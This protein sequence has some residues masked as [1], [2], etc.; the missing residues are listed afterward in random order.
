M[1]RAALLVSTKNKTTAEINRVTIKLFEPVKPAFWKTMT[2]DN[3]R[4][5]CGHEK[6]S[7]RLKL[8]SFF[9]NPYHS[10]ERG[11][12]EHT[13]GLIREFYPKSKNFK[14]VK[15]EDFQKAVDSSNRRPRKSLDYRTPLRSILC[16][17]RPCCISSLNWRKM[18]LSPFLLINSVL[19]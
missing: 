9:A 1:L 8:E 4:E 10:W 3:G 6:L 14:I 5:F 12:N 16:F 7:E 2:F 18:S 19:I 17:I 11:L 15:E 13:N